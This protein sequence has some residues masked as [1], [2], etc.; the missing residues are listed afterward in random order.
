MAR[1]WFFCGVMGTSVFRE[2]GGGGGGAWRRPGA[3]EAPKKSWRD[4]ARQEEPDREDRPPIRR[5][6]PERRDDRDRP[7]PSREPE[8]G[9]TSS[10]LCRHI[11]SFAIKL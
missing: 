9:K 8:E 11:S 4:S 5:E 2:E 7:P 6:R 10:V 1:C 3:D